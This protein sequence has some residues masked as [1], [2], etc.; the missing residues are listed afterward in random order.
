MILPTIKAPIFQG[1]SH[2]PFFS[3]AKS[4]AE[5]LELQLLPIDG[6]QNR[7]RWLWKIDRDT[8]KWMVYNGKS[9]WNG[10]FGG[11]PYFAETPTS[12]RTDEKI[13]EMWTSTTRR[14]LPVN[15]TKKQ[16]NLHYKLLRNGYLDG[17]FKSIFG[18]S[19]RKLTVLWTFFG[20]AKLSGPPKVGNNESRCKA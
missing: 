13:K 9:Y 15:R 14:L 19:R 12:S 7:S 17:G 4:K 20:L 5:A 2:L 8:P 16:V 1:F 10:I 6:A 3:F 11:Y 18:S